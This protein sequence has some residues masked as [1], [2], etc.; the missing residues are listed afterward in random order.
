MIFFN[1]YLLPSL[2]NKTQSWGKSYNMLFREILKLQHISNVIETSDGSWQSLHK[3]I[4]FYKI[5]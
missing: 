1:V 5:Y 4:R 3:Y 2:Y